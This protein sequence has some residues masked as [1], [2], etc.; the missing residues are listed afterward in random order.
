[1]ANPLIGFGMVCVVNVARRRLAM[2][3]SAVVTVAIKMPIHLNAV[4]LLLL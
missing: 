2:V 3:T 4:T 1:M